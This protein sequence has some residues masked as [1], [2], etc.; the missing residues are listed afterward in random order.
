MGLQKRSYQNSKL[1]QIKN[2][3]L[4]PRKYKHLKVTSE[5]TDGVEEGWSNT[6]CPCDNTT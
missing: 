6:L 5:Q 4:F 1:F 3:L 2:L